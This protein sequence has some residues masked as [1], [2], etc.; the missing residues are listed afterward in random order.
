[1]LFSTELMRIYLF[2]PALCSSTCTMPIYLLTFTFLFNFVW[3]SA[4]LDTYEKFIS[5]AWISQKLFALLSK[6]NN[7]INVFVC[8]YVC[9]CSLLYK[10]VNCISF[11]TYTLMLCLTSCI[12]PI[13]GDN[14]TVCFVWN[15]IPQASNI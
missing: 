9:E 3:S 4:Y 6:Y 12:A 7:H 5:T 1:M 10:N 14:V 8:M 15:V 2:S 13:Y 11:L